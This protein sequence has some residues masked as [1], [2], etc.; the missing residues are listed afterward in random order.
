[1]SQFNNENMDNKSNSIVL[2]LETLNA[3]YRNL[4]IE[5]QQAVLNYANFLREETTQ[6]N[7]KNKTFVSI[8]G[9][10][11]VGPSNISQNFSGTLEECKAS[12]AS[13]NGCT[14][15]TFNQTDFFGQPLCLLAGGE[16]S[17]V[18]ESPGNYAIVPKG[19]QLLLIV[20]KINQQLKYINEQIREKTKE[21]KPLYNTQTQDRSIQNNELINQ[22]YQL[23]EERKRI[24]NMINEY[25]TL[26]QEQKQGS[27]KINQNYYSFVLLLFLAIIVLFILYKFFGSSTNTSTSTQYG[28]DSSINI[29]YI[30][31]GVFLF[32]LFAKFIFNHL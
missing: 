28:G 20:Q 30:I 18:S 27:I 2:D 4:L 17:I 6:Q 23:V 11:Y 10:V 16:G 26:D 15:A 13:T 8:P 3:N 7:N 1:M 21:G 25:Q 9:S 19:K 29:F 12:C 24:D 32:I 5:Y 22:F 31:F 14:G